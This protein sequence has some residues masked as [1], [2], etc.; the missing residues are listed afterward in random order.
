[1][2]NLSQH[3]RIR[4]NEGCL[5]AHALNLIGD[6]WALLVVRELMF[7]PKRF[8]MIR[9][10]LPG[11]TASVLT[12]RLNQLGHAGIVDHNSV[13]GLYSLTAAGLALHPVLTELCRWAL[14]VPGHDP[15]R[16]IS[17]SA[18]MISISATVN[19]ARAVNFRLPAGIRCG[20]ESFIVTFPTQGEPQVR[21]SRHAQ[22]VFVL[23]GSGNDLAAAFYGPVPVADMA[24]GGRVA[25]HGD[26][27][28]AQ[29]FVDLFSL[30]AQISPSSESPE[31]MEHTPG[32]SST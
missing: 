18:L 21:A 4:Y 17:I 29:E 1:M 22:G 31:V 10:G 2:T 32:L 15:Q 27:A 25:L 3:P 16:F 20:H 23:E 28:A 26:N 14:H 24:V 5:G 11:I 19:R 9:A 7:A 30:A 12:Q 8:Q 13:L 6:R